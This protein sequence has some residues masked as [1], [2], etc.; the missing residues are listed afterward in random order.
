ME[1][2]TPAKA[3]KILDKQN[4][5]NRS[6][7]HGVVEKY[8]DDMRNGR[9]TRCVV[10]ISFFSDGTLADGQHRLFAVIESGVPQTFEVLHG[11]TKEDMLNIDTGLN[12]TLVD[13]VS[14]AGLN[15]TLSNQ[16][17]SYARGVHY[18][19]RGSVALSNT[20]RLMLVETYR[21][22]LEWTISNGPKGHSIRNGPVMSAIARAHMHNVNLERLKRF[23]EVL[24]NGQSNGMQDSAAVTL[25]NYLKNL[26]NAASRA[27]VWRET[28]LKVQNSIKYFVANKELKVI[29][30]VLEEA[31][32]LPAVPKKRAAKA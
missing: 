23:C 22:H 6:L 25:R 13:S 4:T 18:G 20:K 10:P 1:T 31:Y 12:R 32:P 15:I 24:T 7:R 30:G 19:D 9:W 28:F 26:G 16:L 5:S 11:I 2:F 29:K 27:S 3:Q 21:P 14:L 8:A 17:L